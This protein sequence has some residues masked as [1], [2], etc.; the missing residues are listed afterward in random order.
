MKNGCFTNKG[1][2]RFLVFAI[3]NRKSQ[4]LLYFAT[5]FYIII[6]IFLHFPTDSAKI[7]KNVEVYILEYIF[8]EHFFIFYRFI[9]ELRLCRNKAFFSPHR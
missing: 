3:K 2:I 7:R 6:F 5:V 1:G 8:A 9:R 4:F